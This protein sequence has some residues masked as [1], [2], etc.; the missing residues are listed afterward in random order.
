MKSSATSSVQIWI[1]ADATERFLSKLE[2]VCPIRLR[3][4][5]SSAASLSRCSRKRRESWREL[6]S[7]S[8]KLHL[9]DII[10]R[11][12]KTAKMAKSHHNVG[13]LPDDMKLELVEL[14]KTSSS[15][16]K[17]AHVVSSWDCRDYAAY[18]QPFRTGLCVRNCLGAITRDRLEAV[19]VSPDAILR[20][21]F[22]KAGL[23]K[24]VW[25]HFTVVPDFKSVGMRNHARSF[26][27]MVIIRAINTIDAM[28]A[29]IEKVDWGVEVI[30]NRIL[31][32]G[33][34]CEPGFAMI[35]RRSLRLR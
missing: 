24:K 13:G 20:E 28:T 5:R 27:Y 14:V 7:G 22:E 16:M 15:R 2:N 1:Y 34:E 29:S 19:R 12:R 6:I 9:S 8:G 23:D 25:Q 35:C 17:C 31:N 4:V 10:E 30:T 33:C 11:E 21:E 18:R 26:E 3:N 32:E